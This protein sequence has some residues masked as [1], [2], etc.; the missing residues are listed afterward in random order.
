MNLSLHTKKDS[1]VISRRL[2]SDELDL[3]LVTVSIGLENAHE[4]ERLP[5]GSRM[6]DG[7]RDALLIDID[8][9]SDHF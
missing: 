2:Q 8:F 5:V 6:T 4:S 7:E 1:P 3:S 9:C